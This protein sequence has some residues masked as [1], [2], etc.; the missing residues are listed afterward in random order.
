MNEFK[1]GSVGLSTDSYLRLKFGVRV[2]EIPATPSESVSIF[3]GTDRGGVLFPGLGLRGFLAHLDG[4]H[5]LSDF[6]TSDF[7]SSDEISSALSEL[8]QANLLVIANEKL[9]TPA[10]F[11]SESHRISELRISAEA[12]LA[13]WNSATQSDGRDVVKARADFAILIFGFSR[14]AIALFSILQAS[15]FSQTKIISGERSKM[16]TSGKRTSSTHI[17]VEEICGLNVTLADVGKSRNET[18]TKIQHS[19]QLVPDKHAN[20]PA[21]PNLVISTETAQPDY[22]QRWMSEGVAHLQISNLHESFIEVG[23]LVIPGISPC[24]RCVGMQ[25]FGA[26]KIQGMV[27]FSNAMESTPELSSAS[28]ATI[29]G[30]VAAIVIQLADTGRSPL[31]Q[32]SIRYNLLDICNPEH[33]YWQPHIFCGCLEVI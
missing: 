30:L 29:S 19:A 32:K 31:M 8:R 2:L 16:T 6:L 4:S 23:P 9:W 12:N 24:L 17:R 10:P 25:K 27:E 11:T 20:F 21:I 5:R 14:V 28:A 3:V 22:I 33:I 26:H 13:T 18:I 15:G 7:Y 1:T